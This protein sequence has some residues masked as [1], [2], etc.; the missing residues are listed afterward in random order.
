[1]S[2]GADW[3]WGQCQKISKIGQAG[4]GKAPVCACV[5]EEEGDGG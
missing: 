5:Q 1:M 4:V 3:G 2:R